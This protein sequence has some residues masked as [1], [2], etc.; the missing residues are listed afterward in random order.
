MSITV[1]INWQQRK[2][3]VTFLQELP[4]LEMALWTFVTNRDDNDDD[5]N[6][7]HT[8]VDWPSSQVNFAND[9][10]FDENGNYDDIGNG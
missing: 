9:D 2:S 10:D 7:G 4:R 1:Q 3:F 6:D 8:K 5:D